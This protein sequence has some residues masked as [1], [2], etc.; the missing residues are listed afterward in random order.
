MVHVV[1][2]YYISYNNL[3][4][5]QRLYANGLSYLKFNWMLKICTIVLD[6]LGIVKVEDS[7]FTMYIIAL[8]LGWLLDCS[9]FKE[10]VVRILFF[11][12]FP[13]LFCFD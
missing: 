13:G 3:S 7:Q 2:S 5:V 10:G 4:G 6:E 12:S 8:L 9:V 11:F 1:R